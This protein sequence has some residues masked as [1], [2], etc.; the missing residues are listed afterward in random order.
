MNDFK[1]ISLF[2]FF[3]R[4]FLSEEETFLILKCTVYFE[5]QRRKVIRSFQDAIST[6]TCQVACCLMS[7]WLDRV[8]YLILF[9]ISISSKVF[10]FLFLRNKTKSVQIGK[11]FR[12]VLICGKSNIFIHL[13]HIW[14]YIPISQTCFSVR[15]S[16]GTNF[17]ASIS[18]Q[19][20][21]HMECCFHFM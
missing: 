17:S 3:R 9:R 12:S 10:I 14:I 7:F 6:S 15:N 1:T 4:A 21:I 8:K 18:S 20:S 11:G 13:V 5:K 2:G 19:A 16:S